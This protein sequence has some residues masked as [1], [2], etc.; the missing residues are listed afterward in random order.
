MLKVAFLGNCQAQSLES[1]VGG[2]ATDVSVAAL[3][4]IWLITESEAPKIL[5]IIASQDIVF[6]QRL[7]EDFGV[8]PL[9]TKELRK[10]FGTK[11]VSWPNVYFDGYFPGLGYKYVGLGEKVLGPLDEY[12]WDVI[13]R[14]HKGGYSVDDCAKSLV[15][16]EVFEVHADPFAK[17]FASLSGRE[18]ELDIMMSDY[19]VSRIGGPRMFYSMN[20]PTNELLRELAERQFGFIGERKR[21]STLSTFGYPLNK[22]VVPIL[23]AIARRYHVNS[24]EALFEAK[25]VAVSFSDD[26]YSVSNDPVVY[27]AADL[28]ETYY[29]CYDRMSE[30]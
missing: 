8:V 16:D 19:I 5:D 25:G 3:P 9:R 18:D 7:S 6:A 28:V 21:L 30:A 17:S 2:Q 20:H 1:W 4:P 10:T 23:P 26:A 22:I 11:V 24:G 27:S 29:R 13:E 15:G 12:H 14:G